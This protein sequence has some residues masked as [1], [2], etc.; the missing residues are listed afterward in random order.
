MSLG[1]QDTKRIIFVGKNNSAVAGD[2]VERP[3]ILVNSVFNAKFRR[4]NVLDLAADN[5]HDGAA[6]RRTGFH[7]KLL[8]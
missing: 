2:I 5:L 3:A 1:I 6:T 8:V 4:Q 7:E